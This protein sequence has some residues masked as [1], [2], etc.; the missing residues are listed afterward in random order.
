LN[1]VVIGFVGYMLLMAGIGIWSYLKT[2]GETS[3]ES[4]IV[5]NRDFGPVLTAFGVGTTLASGYAF[6]GLVG[7]AYLMGSMALFQPIFTTIMEAI[8]WFK[9][10]KKIRRLSVE[11]GSL[12]PIEL[13]SNLRGDPYNLIKIIGGLMVS[14]FI[15]FYLAGQFISGAKAATVLGIPFDT[16]VWVS[17]LVV[18]AYVFLGGVLAVMWTDAIQGFMMV[19][20]FFLLMVTVLVQSGGFF[21]AFESVSKVT[22]HIVMWTNGKSGLAMVIP[23]LTWFGVGWNFWGQP[24]A[25][26]KFLTVKDE[27]SLPAAAIMSIG[28]NTIRQYVPIMMGLCGRV[29]FDNL[30]DPELLTPTVVATYFPN[31][32]GGLAL[33]SIF[34]AIM[35][36]TDSLILQSTGE[37]TRNVMQLG[38]LKN[39]SDKTIGY[40]VKIMT[41]VVAVGGLAIAMGTST[42]QFTMTLFAFAGLSGAITGPLWLGILWDKCTSWG[43][44]AGVSLG[45]PFTMWWFY[46]MKASTGLG[47]GIVANI[48]SFALV[49]IVSL[50][51]QK[52]L[53]KDKPD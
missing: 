48:G 37:F 7:A 9:L 14:L 13:I 2:R 24:Q 35:S 32:L 15:M 26:Q 10:S 25:I 11:T 18:L 51:T 34:A 49:F 44:L 6:I 38:L 50:L 4:F 19:F 27:E 29:L 53:K 1:G 21:N 17:A 8:L 46:N 40:A 31:V 20:T 39:A 23:I 45:I 36:T 30:K 16:A 5:G 47:E 12:T 22:P 41:I 52:S 42:N 43:I 28:F 3:I 33:A